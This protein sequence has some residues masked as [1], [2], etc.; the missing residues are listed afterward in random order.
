LPYLPS[1]EPQKHKFALD[2]CTPPNKCTDKNTHVCPQGER[3]SMVEE[4]RKNCTLTA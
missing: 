1:P 3:I 4:W 2:C